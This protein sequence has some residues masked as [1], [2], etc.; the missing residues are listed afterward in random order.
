M[1]RPFDAASA[2]RPPGSTGWQPTFVRLARDRGPAPRGC[3]EEDA[4]C[5][6]LPPALA[7]PG[8]GPSRECTASAR[9]TTPTGAT[10]RVEA[11]GPDGPR[12]P[13]PARGALGGPT[14]SS[15]T[16]ASLIHALVTEGRISE[17]SVYCTGD[18]DARV[19][20]AACTICPFEPFLGFVPAADR[21]CLSVDDLSRSDCLGRVPG[22]CWLAPRRR[23]TEGDGEARD[24]PSSVAPPTSTEVDGDL[25][26]PRRR[27]AR[28]GP[29]A[30]SSTSSPA[31]SRCGCTRR[32]T[33]GTRA[34][35]PRARLAAAL[36]RCWAYAN[37]A[38][39]RAPLRARGARPRPRTPWTTRPSSPTPS[40]RRWRRVGDPTTWPGA[41]PWAVRLDDVAAHLRDPDARLQAQLWGLA[42]AWEGARPASDAPGPCTPIELLAEESPGP[43]SSASSS[44]ACMAR[45][46]RGRSSASHATVSPQSW[47]CSRGRG[48][49]VGRDVVEPDGP[50]AAPGQV[51][52]APVRRQRRV[53]GVGEEGRVVQGVGE[54]ERLDAKGRASGS[55][56]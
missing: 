34:G 10:V 56:A 9:A 35:A 25:G 5:D 53:E 14:G 46:I 45:C 24:W 37:G 50:G 19:A 20:A 7:G 1:T 38:A 17:L 36:A 15:G 41:A 55:F 51:V 48:P 29:R 11:P 33:P 54:V 23:G 21:P 4:F 39:P 3:L 13:P 8:R 32:T 18:W 2:A 44:M 16:A 26:T 49:E 28:P 31:C 40:T 42:V 52:G 6:L 47:A 27:G 43:G 22:A 12:L 30:S